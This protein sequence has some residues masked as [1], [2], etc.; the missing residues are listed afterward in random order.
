PLKTLP[1]VTRFFLGEA[2]L[3]KWLR[4][5][6]RRVLRKKSADFYP[7]TQK[8]IPGVSLLPI[9]KRTRLFSK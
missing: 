6:A 1:N 3:L 8:A 5:L 9:L 7:Y 2:L 4:S